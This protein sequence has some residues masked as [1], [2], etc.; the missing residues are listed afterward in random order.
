MLA[1]K[2]K[3]TMCAQTAIFGIGFCVLYCV[4]YEERAVHTSDLQDIL[5]YSGL[6]FRAG[7]V[8][9][10]EHMCSVWDTSTWQLLPNFT[11][12]SKCNIMLMSYPV[13]GTE[14]KQHLL[15]LRI[16]EAPQL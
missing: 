10:K 6:V 7:T 4:E 2:Q 13:S 8:H 14:L 5:P 16:N 9:S 15:I 12:V 1:V 11:H 3:E